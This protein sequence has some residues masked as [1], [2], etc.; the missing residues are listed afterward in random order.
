MPSPSPVDDESSGFDE[1]KMF[2]HELDIALHTVLVLDGGR[3]INSHVTQ[4]KT[5]QNIIGFSVL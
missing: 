2:D 1:L 4:T 3:S 5:K